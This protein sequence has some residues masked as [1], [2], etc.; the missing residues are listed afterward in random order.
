MTLKVFGSESSYFSLHNE[1]D[2]PIGW[3]RDRTLGFRCFDSVPEARAAA[4]IAYDV[5]IAACARIGVSSMASPVG[6]A[7]LRIVHDGASEWFTNGGMP[8]AR[9]LPARA[10]AAGDPTA[11]YG[12][13]LIV[14]RGVGPVA[15]IG[16]AQAIHVALERGRP[17]VLAR[18]RAA[19]E[20]AAT[21]SAERDDTGE[22]EELASA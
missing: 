18:R 19:T 1:N 6:N 7:P 14:P 3:I 21:H 2:V 4:R 13:E 5:M 22:L 15:S 12:I 20:R 17:T 10:D 8:I 11:S 16:I 9:L